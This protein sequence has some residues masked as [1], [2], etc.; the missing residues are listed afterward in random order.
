MVSLGLPKHGIMDNKGQER[1]VDVIVL[2]TG[3]KANEFPWPMEVRG[4]EGKSAE[5]L[6]EKDG[7]RAYLGA[8]LPGF[9]NF[10]MVYG[11]NTNPLGGAGNPAI[12]EMGTRFIVSCLAHLILND[13]STVDVIFDAYERY[14]D[15]VDKAEDTRIYARAG[16]KNYFTNEYGRSP[17]NCPFDARKMWEWFRDPTGRYAESTSGESFNAD[18]H[19]HPYFGQDLI[20]E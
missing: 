17:G 10:F 16:V 18:S 1:A 14:N 7:P 5:Q 20:V 15:E 6:W 4:R 11:P 9:P 2:A 12:H 8:M 19:V 3:F 13:E